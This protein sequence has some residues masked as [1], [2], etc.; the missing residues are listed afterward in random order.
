MMLE[1]NV[2]DIVD[3]V[4]IV[5]KKSTVRSRPGEMC[6]VFGDSNIFAKN[7]VACGKRDYNIVKSVFDSWDNNCVDDVG[8]LFVGYVFSTSNIGKLDGFILDKFDLCSLFVVKGKP[9]AQKFEGLLGWDRKKSIVE[10][11]DVG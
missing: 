2:P 8:Y 3:I 5:I 10:E 4:K 7:F 6:F 9:A 11:C 1:L